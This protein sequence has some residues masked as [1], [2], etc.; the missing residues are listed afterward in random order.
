MLNCIE[1][2]RLDFIEEPFE[3]TIPEVKISLNERDRFSDS[4][5]KLVK[6]GA[7]E[8]CNPIKNQFIL[9]YFLIPKP[10]GSFRFILN[11]KRLNLFIKC[12]ILQWKT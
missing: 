9:P 11:L 1:G 7:I 2:Y 10:D 6:K 4:I 5:G 3:E 8:I 12:P